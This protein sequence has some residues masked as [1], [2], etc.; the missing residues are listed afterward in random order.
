MRFFVTKTGLDA[1]DVARVWGLAVVLNTATEKEVKIADADWAFLVE[2]LAPPK[3]PFNETGWRPLFETTESLFWNRV[4][5]TQRG[6]VEESVTEVR[7]V[8]EG[9]WEQLLSLQQPQ[10][11][12]LGSGKTLPG[13]LEPAAFKGVR[14]PTKASFG[15]G[16]LRAVPLHWALACLGMATCGLYRAAGRD[17]WVALLLVPQQA[18]FYYFREVTDILQPKG[19]RRHESAQTT[20]AHYAVL[21]AENLRQRAAAQESLQDRFSAVLYFSLF[22]TGQQVKPS[23]GSQLRI[24]PLMDAITQDPHNTESLLRWLDACFQLGAAKGAEGVGLAATELLMRWDLDAFDKLTHT[25]LRAI[26]Q[27]SLQ[28][29]VPSPFNHVLF[30][31]GAQALQKA[32]EVMGSARAFGGVSTPCRS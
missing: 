6:R 1:F 9:G 11:D 13:G 19:L 18:T 21:V 28:R 7:Q 20:A 10:W 32:M 3:P 25:L 8:I 16:Q 30:A 4:F 31:T 14:H 23:Q 15:E 22:R 29:T 27:K 17:Q 24:T 5:V 26:G 2:T 12:V